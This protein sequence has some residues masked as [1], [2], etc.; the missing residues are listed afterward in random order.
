MK[1]GKRNRSGEPES[2]TTGD[3]KQKRKRLVKS[4]RTTVASTESTCTQMNPVSS[5]ESDDEEEMDLEAQQ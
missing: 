3:F 1:S 2:A 4:K 5:T